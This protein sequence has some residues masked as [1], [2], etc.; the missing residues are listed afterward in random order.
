MFGRAEAPLAALYDVAHNIAKIETHE[1]G[2]RCLQVLVHRKGA[3]RAFPPGHQELAA[4]WQQTGQPVIIPGSMGTASYV[5]AGTR[6]AMTESFGTCAHGAG[7]RMSRSKA[8]RMIRG[9]ELQEQLLRGGIVVE[10]GSPAELAEEAPMAYK[11]V[12]S[13]VDVV[14]RAGI[15]RKIAEL[16][17]VAVMKG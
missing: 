14:H 9:A 15:A 5:L 3:T 16:R 7:R 11:D 6:R 10:S 13:V 4:L 12:R 8:R 1:V 2:G 17:P